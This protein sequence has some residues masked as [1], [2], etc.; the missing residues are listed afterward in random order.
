VTVFR[1]SESKVDGKRLR[2]ARDVS[3]GWG[4]FAAEIDVHLLPGNH[5]SMVT[6]HGAAVGERLTV[7]LRAAL[8]RER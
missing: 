7:C 1:A 3:L 6:E 5:V 8:S 2:P 4:R